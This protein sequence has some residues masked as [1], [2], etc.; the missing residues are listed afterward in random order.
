MDRVREIL[1]QHDY[2]I[3]VDSNI[4]LFERPWPRSVGVN[5]M[6]VSDVEDVI[7]K[8]DDQTNK[9]EITDK[10]DPNSSVSH[11]EKPVSL[12]IYVSPLFDQ[13]IL[14][15]TFQTI[16]GEQSEIIQI[17]SSNNKPWLK[18][19]KCGD[20]IV[21]LNGVVIKGHDHVH[22]EIRTNK[23]FCMVLE[24]HRKKK[25]KRWPWNRKHEC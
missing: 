10:N 20:I 4:V 11:D 14:G 13:D 12:F 19:I 2:V 23:H 1:V 22:N 3:D 15:I 25:K 18:D 7:T 16:H 8:D 24:L 9:S 21:A 5:V 17:H 6:A